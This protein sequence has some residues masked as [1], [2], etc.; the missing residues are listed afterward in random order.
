MNKIWSLHG[1]GMIDH[2]G[3]IHFSYVWLCNW[4]HPFSISPKGKSPKAL[5]I[6]QTLPWKAA[7]T[8]CGTMQFLCASTTQLVDQPYTTLSFVVGFKIHHHKPQPTGFPHIGLSELLL[9]SYKARETFL[10]SYEYNRKTKRCLTHLC[11][12]PR[13]TRLSRRW[14]KPGVLSCFSHLGWTKPKR[15][16]KGYGVPNWHY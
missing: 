16:R 9:T 6:G 3:W 7:P 14:T 15:K 10:V 8:K 2:L 4:K 1:H 12:I 11:F 5:H 13:S